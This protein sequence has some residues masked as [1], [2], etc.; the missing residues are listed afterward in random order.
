[1]G[2]INNRNV[3]SKRISYQIAKFCFQTETV[4]ADK[5]CGGSETDADMFRRG[6]RT[7]I[8][9]QKSHTGAGQ[10]KVSNYYYSETTDTY[11]CPAGCILKYTSYTPRATAFNLRRMIMLLRYPPIKLEN[12]LIILGRRLFF[13]CLLFP[14]ILFISK[15]LHMGNSL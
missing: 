10:F 7:Y 15:G 6:I 1:M 13:K 5:G 14:P 3:H 4:C 8:P 12:R 9:R 11:R 2:N